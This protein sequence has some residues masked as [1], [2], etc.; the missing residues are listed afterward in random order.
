M[1]VIVT[2]AKD[3]YFV[4][5]LHLFYLCGSSKINVQIIYLLEDSDVYA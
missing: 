5:Y 4:L 3:G 1:K 2:I